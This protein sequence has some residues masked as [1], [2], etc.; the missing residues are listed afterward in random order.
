MSE[1]PTK[2]CLSGHEVAVWDFYRD[3]TRP[4]GF[5]PYC[6]DC[7]KEKI[8]RR[9]REMRDA[10]LTTRDSYKPRRHPKEIGP[11]IEVTIPEELEE[12]LKPR[13]HRE[14]VDNGFRVL[15]GSLEVKKERAW[16]AR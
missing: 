11:R 15:F 14:S 12:V 9:R 4:D 16:Q 8:Y 1:I 10:G 3:R 13:V 2:H 5:A 7:A 6:K